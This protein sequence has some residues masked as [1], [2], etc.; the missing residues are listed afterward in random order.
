MSE[1][2]L[3]IARA[4]CADRRNGTE[5]GIA[6]VQH[7]DA[8]A[9]GP[10]EVDGCEK[11]LERAKPLRKRMRGG[12]ELDHLPVVTL[13]VLEGFGVRLEHRPVVRC[14]RG[15]ADDADAAMVPDHRVL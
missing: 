10:G 2:A 9:L 5:G 4:A 12:R 3:L 6:L 8:V 1:N 11:A 13:A 15:P 7:R 14:R